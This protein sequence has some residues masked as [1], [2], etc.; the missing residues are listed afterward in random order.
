EFFEDM[1]IKLIDYFKLDKE[2]YYAL[3]ITDIKNERAY[4]F[5]S[6]FSIKAEP[7]SEEEFKQ[8]GK[9]ALKNDP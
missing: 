1:G 2:H 5:S 3:E 8:K 7:V 6:R 9:E 4:K